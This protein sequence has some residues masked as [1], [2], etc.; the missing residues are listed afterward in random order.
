MLQYR[1]ASSLSWHVLGILTMYN[2]ELAQKQQDAAKRMFDV[3]M[4]SRNVVSEFVVKS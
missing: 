2:A 4:C 3:H 1:L